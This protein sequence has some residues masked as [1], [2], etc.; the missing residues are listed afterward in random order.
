MGRYRFDSDTLGCLMGSLEA[1]GKDV[2]P[3]LVQDCSAVLRK[4]PVPGGTDSTT[5]RI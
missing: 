1:N 4:V 2:S 3:L 5:E